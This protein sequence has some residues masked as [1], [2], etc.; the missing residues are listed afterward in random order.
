MTDWCILRTSGRTTLRLAE[1]LR[2]DGFEAWTPKQTSRVR[3]PRCNVR[4]EVTL[5]LM[6]S[7]VFVASRHL[8]DMLERAELATEDFSVFRYLDRFPIV[9]DVDLEPL[10]LAETRAIP[11]AR[12]QAFRRGDTVL[13]PSGSFAGMSGI[14]ER[15][16]GRFTLVS[17]GTRMRVKISTF[18]LKPVVGISRSSQLGT[19][20]REAA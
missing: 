17:F 2:R 9:A 12:R 6:P 16:D 14:V 4:R 3:I 15:S 19:A 11:T 7:F 20:A 18:I 10:R 13:V 8:I 1:Q 5:P